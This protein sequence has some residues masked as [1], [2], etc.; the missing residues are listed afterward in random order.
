MMKPN[1]RVIAAINLQESDRVPSAVTLGYFV[2]RHNGATIEKYITD[3]DLYMELHHKTFEELGGSDLVN[4]RP[5]CLIDSPKRFAYMPVKVKLPG[6][7]LPSN[8]IPQYDEK[9]LMVPDDYEIIIEKGWFRY[10]EEDLIPAVYPE[11]MSPDTGLVKKPRH[12]PDWNYQYFR[13]KDI[14]IYPDKPI[15]L[16]FEVLSFARSMSKFLLDLYRRPDT[17][18]AAMDA[19]MN[20]MVDDVLARINASTTTVVIPANRCSSGFISPR[21]FERFA[22]P[23]LL[24]MV[25]LLVSR[26]LIV[27]FHL[28]QN[29]TGVLPYFRQFP[30]GKYV[31]HF[32]GMTDVFAAKEILGDRMCLMGDVPARLFKIGTPDDIDRYCHKLI[33]TIGRGSGFI[34][35]AG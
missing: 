16:P 12:E 3:P 24:Q 19:I 25:D 32:D 11:P 27:F 8:T 30:Q 7:T 18:L 9:E 34:L 21:Y 20:D 6:K 4:I 10:V 14:F 13:N 31:L 1:E 23:Q 15:S 35:A 2:A 5:P 29:W 33:D 17:V 22:L 28:D 26:G